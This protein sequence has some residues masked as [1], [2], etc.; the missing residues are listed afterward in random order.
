MTEE[1]RKSIVKPT[2]QTPYHID[3]SWWQETDRDWEI[4]LKNLLCIEHRDMFE[5][6]A[7]NGIIDWVDPETAEVKQV[8]GLQH[9]LLSHCARRED[10]LGEHTTVVEAIF[11]IFIMN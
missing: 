9:V 11:R 5:E 3:F 1:Q 7:D 8:D 4:Y 2:A 10:F 6:A